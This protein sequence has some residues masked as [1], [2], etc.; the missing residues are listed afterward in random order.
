MAFDEVRLP[1]EIEQGA[2]GG[3]TFQT[4]VLALSS[5]FERRNIDWE[6]ARM[7]WD[8]AYGIMSLD[9][10]TADVYIDLVR[11]FFFARQG[12]ANGFRFKDWSDYQ[13]DNVI[14]QTDGSTA[15]HQVLKAY[16]DLGSFT[17]NREI[18]KIVT[19]T[20]T[21]T[22]NSV[23]I[24]EGGGA[25][26]YQLDDTTGILTLGSTLATQSGTDIE[27]ACEF[28]TPVRFADDQLRISLLHAAGT[29]AGSIPSIPIIEVRI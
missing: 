27:V 29:G 5:G 19:G 14:G 26:Q 3:P 6:Q 21:V 16:T 25:S 28:D 24:S 18:K 22:V 13:L 2:V 8:L 9:D 10:T 11:N 20:E 1:E 15:A 4:R 23:V 17:Y 12:R 7:S